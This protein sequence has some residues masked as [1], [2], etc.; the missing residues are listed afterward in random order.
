MLINPFDNM[1]INPVNNPFLINSLTNSVLFNLNNRGI[2]K[3]PNQQPQSG[4]Y[5]SKIT[6]MNVKI[7]K[8]KK[9]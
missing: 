5:E 9:G 2:F 8:N 3:L 1:M 4:P 7:K 6:N